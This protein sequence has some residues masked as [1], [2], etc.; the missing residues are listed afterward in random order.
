MNDAKRK[1]DSLIASLLELRQQAVLLEREFAEQLAAIPPAYRP[2]GANLVHYLS[3]RQHDIRELQFELHTLGLSSLGRM[4]A[5]VLPTI[6]AVLLAL[7]KL[8]DRP[9][10][11]VDPPPRP[12][13]FR[14]GRAQLVNNTVALFG[15]QRSDREPRIMVT[16]PSESAD[17][18]DLIHQLVVAG[19]DVL[20][21]NCSQDNPQRWGQMIEHLRRAEK[22]TGSRC[23]VQMDLEG[24][25]PRTGEV[26][27]KGKFS[28]RLGDQLVLTRGNLAGGPAVRDAHENIIEPAH[29]GCTLPEVFRDVRPGERFFYDDGNLAGI[30]REVDQDRAVLEVTHTR[31]EVAKIKSGKGVNFPDTHFGLPALTSKDRQDLDFVA[32]NADLIGF[33][34][35]RHADDVNDLLAELKLRQAEDRSIIL[36]I[37]TQLAFQNLPEMLLTAMRHPPVGVM[38]ARGD[39]GVEIGF[40]RM[41]EVQEEILWLCEAAHVPVVWA[42]QVLENLAKTGLPTRAEVTDAA[43]SGRAECV[44]LNKGKHIVETVQFLS[45]VLQRMQ[46]HQHKKLATLRKLSISNVHALHEHPLQDWL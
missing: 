45:D 17:Q 7:C 34:F 13:G 12:E 10:P 15:S 31:K 33:S 28:V 20:R 18:Y 19:M 3:I 42:T 39:M 16:A 1:F 9:V 46:Q 5:Y 29:V 24:P 11:S 37:E 38:V 21:I 22:E 36:K 27:G 2:S 41:S 35:V 26:G 8:A 25:N 43:M 4:E 14:A 44:M 6:D 40:N 23:K 32:R 30:V